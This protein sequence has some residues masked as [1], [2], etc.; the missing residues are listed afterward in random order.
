MN[1]DL[2]KKI[3]QNRSVL[4]KW[5]KIKRRKCPNG[6]NDYKGGRCP[7]Q[8]CLEKKNLHCSYTD[9]KRLIDKLTYEAKVAYFGGE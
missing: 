8:E 3:L 6:F 9:N 1:E 4:N 7:C 2:L 5:R